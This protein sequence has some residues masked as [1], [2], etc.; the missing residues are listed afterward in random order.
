MDGDYQCLVS[1]AT[2]MNS[3]LK[4]QARIDEPFAYC[5]VIIEEEDVFSDELQEFEDFF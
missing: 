2:C 4:D 1:N 3:P 5:K